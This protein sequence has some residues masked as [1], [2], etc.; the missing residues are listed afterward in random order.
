MPLNAQG[1]YIDNGEKPYEVEAAYYL[2]YYI[3]SA[4]AA[5]EYID[6]GFPHHETVFDN[7]I[8]YYHYHSDH[9]LY[10]VGQISNRFIIVE[11]D[12]GLKLERKKANRANCRFDDT[13]F[14]ILSNKKARN[15]IEHIDE[16]N[17][18]IIADMHGVGGFNLIDST[19]DSKLLDTLYNRK[20]THIY[21]LDL[22][23][24]KIYITRKG[25]KITI[26][27][28]ALKNELLTLQGNVNNFASLLALH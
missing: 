15:T 17:Q 4:L 13:V 7:R 12:S 14:P 21:T 22:L 23:K 8:Q 18:G 9:L 3:I 19:C 10:A 16:Y 27:M 26:D 20:D 11:K 5:M 6:S 25:E 2:N 28:V 24:R 1:L